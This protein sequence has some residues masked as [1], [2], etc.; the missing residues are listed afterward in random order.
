MTQ[1]VIHP[2]R[3]SLEAVD[4]N[5]EMEAAELVLHGVKTDEDVEVDEVA[6]DEVIE[7]DGG[8]LDLLDLCSSSPAMWT[9]ETTRGR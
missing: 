3:R 8:I 2:W 4:Q 6:L 9:C 7:G 5:G 1:L